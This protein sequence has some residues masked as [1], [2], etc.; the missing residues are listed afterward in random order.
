MAI[1]IDVRCETARPP[2]VSSDHLRLS[3]PLPFLPKFKFCIRSI[4]IIAFPL[5]P[6]HFGRAASTTQSET[7]YSA[8]RKIEEGIKT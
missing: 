8:R 5:H 1:L 7:K 3:H 2:S 6:L 4:S